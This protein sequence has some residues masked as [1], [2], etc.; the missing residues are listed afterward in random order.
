MFGNKLPALIAF[1]LLILGQAHAQGV[2]LTLGPASGSPGSIVNVNISLASTSGA[3]PSALSWTLGYP[4]ADVT[5]VT[6]TVGAAGAAAGK[7]IGCS[8]SSCVLFGL[9]TNP[10]PNGIVAVASVQI[11]PG[12]LATAIRIQITGVAATTAA[13]SM[14]TAAATSGLISVNQPV[15][16]TPSVPLL[17]GYSQS[18]NQLRN[19]F[20]GWVGMQFT[21]GAS[22]LN[23]TSLGRICVSGNSSIHI[24][25]L[26][27]APAWTN[28]PGGSVSVNMSGC[29]PGQFQYANLTNPL[30]LQ[31]GASYY[32][33]SQESAGGDRWF[34]WG[35]VFATTV[36]IVNNPVYSYDGSSWISPILPNMSYGPLNLKY[37]VASIGT[38]QVSVM[39]PVTVTTSPSGLSFSVDGASYTGSQA[40]NWT[41]G[42]AHTI[43]TSALQS[44]PAGTQYVWSTWT[45]G[46][47]LSH[48][49]KATTATTIAANF[50]TQYLL[51]AS[52]APV[53]GG[54][55]TVNPPSATGY[56]DS[57][58]TVQ[59]TAVATGS[60]TF[61]GWSGDLAG[62]ANPQT[63]VMSAPRTVSASFTPPAG[64]S[65]SFV[66]G[67]ALNGP[68]LRSDFGGWV[69]MNLTIGG[70]PLSVTSLGRICIAGNS[71]THV[72][73]FVSASSGSDVAGAAATL[74]MSGCTP[75]QFQY[76]TLPSPITLQ[77]GSSYYLVSNESAGGDLWYDQGTISSTG[78]AAVNGSVYSQNS[79]TWNPINIP[80]YSYVPPNFQYAPLSSAPTVNTPSTNQNAP[81]SS[82][83]F[84]STYSL[85][86][87]LRNDYAG[88]VGMGF[89]VASTPLTV[90]SLGRICAPGNSGLH[91]IKFVSADSGMDVPG[92]SVVVN[93]PGCSQGQFQYANLSSPITL[94]AGGRY[95]IVSQ[96]FHEGDQWYDMVPLSTT[97]S[98][99]VTSAVYSNGASWIPT[100]GS[101]TSY[102]PLNF[103]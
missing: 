59:L 47:A 17:T 45:D 97:A 32:L 34:D 91:T 23:A 75:G 58:S 96:E 42:S 81:S 98:G 57:G 1:S 33:A 92:G 74:N 54:S 38:L 25:K 46:G 30:T 53:A 44:G 21:V 11:A 2:T 4:T 77:A 41:S 22:P 28:V 29:T 31:A 70:T 73:K 85:S 64:S 93:M 62:S 50:G 40:F 56:Y 66:T 60:N 51:T 43:A 7:S 8:G 69:G 68:T 27:S 9:N 101:N 95:Y 37:S 6:W 90:T 49:I 82:A 86:R 14:I 5:G 79:A 67:Y 36:A 18:A 39:V 78:V 13:G 16:S 72:V 80:N 55:I 76:W 10:I 35:V 12:S 71:R 103:Q 3:Q 20:G 63:V 94:Q 19:D 26:V 87:P 84:V 52:V 102:V 89:T 15:T 88:W 83:P 24:V 48:T 61:A 65:S 100:G 99:T